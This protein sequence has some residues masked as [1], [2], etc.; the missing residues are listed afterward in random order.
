VK[1]SG[2]GL[3]ALSHHSGDLNKKDMSSYFSFPYSLEMMELKRV[4]DE[5]APK[6]PLA[7]QWSEN[8]GFGGLQAAKQAYV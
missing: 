1:W 3:F 4:G 5:L 2:L 6:R 7:S 8:A